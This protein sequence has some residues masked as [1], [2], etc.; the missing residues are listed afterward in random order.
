MEKK[1]LSPP[2][3]KSVFE[4]VKKQREPA[5][6]MD[7]MEILAK[8]AE[9][10]GMSPEQIYAGLSMAVQQDPKVRVMRANNTLF[11]YYNLGN[12]QVEILMETADNP[13]TLV[14]SLR[15]FFKAMKIVGFKSGKF[16]V[17]NPQI[18]K[19]IEMAGGK[20]STQSTNQLLSDGKTPALAGIVEF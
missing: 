6:K 10:S 3:E 1:P 13:R 16:G 12:G 15:D 11:V 14:E 9:G 18:L 20:V 2:Q 7:V 5:K 17:E 19:A 4:Q 8:A